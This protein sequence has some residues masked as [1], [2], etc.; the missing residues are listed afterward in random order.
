MPGHCGGSYIVLQ[1]RAG[2]RT[3][4]AHNSRRQSRQSS[5]SNSRNWTEEAPTHLL[6][7]DSSKSTVGKLATIS[8]T[9]KIIFTK[10]STIG[11]YVP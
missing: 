10:P 5:H 3:T 1:P 8:V 6:H 11:L 4:A 2:R 9:I 7:S